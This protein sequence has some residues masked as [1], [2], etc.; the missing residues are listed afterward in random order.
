MIPFPKLHIAESVMN[1]IMN[2]VEDVQPM[3]PSF[4]PAPIPPADPIALGQ[5]IEQQTETPAAPVSMPDD[6]VAAGAAQ[7]SIFGGSPLA[8]AVAGLM[9]Q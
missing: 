7:E 6:P 1:R 3:F 4:N 5:Q 9:E 8:G 2:A